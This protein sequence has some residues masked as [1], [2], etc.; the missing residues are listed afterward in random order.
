MGS[1][2]EKKKERG[3]R[4]GRGERGWKYR[5]GHEEKREKEFS[6]LSSGSPENIHP[7]P[8]NRTLFGKKGLCRLNICN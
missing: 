7:E 2:R 5:N 8:Q 3:K 4:E 1:G 6:G